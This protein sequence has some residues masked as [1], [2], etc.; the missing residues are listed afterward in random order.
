MADPTLPLTVIEYEEWGSPHNPAGYAS[1]AAISPIDNV[2]PGGRY[3]A[4]LATGGLHDPRVGYWEPAKWIATL[5]AKAAPRGPVLLKIDTGAGHFSKSGRFAVLTEK[6]F[7]LAFLLKAVGKLGD[8][9]AA[10]AAVV[11]EEK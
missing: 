4:I 3:P 11:G 1:L 8:K 5:R 2:V 9:K 10:A 6:A 7:E